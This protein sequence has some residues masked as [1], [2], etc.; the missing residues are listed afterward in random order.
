VLAARSGH[1]ANVALARKMRELYTKK[2]I[3]GRYNG[4]KR[5]ALFDINAILK[6]MPHRY[7]M[8]L[9][10][11]IVDLVPD[12]SVVAIKNVTI[13]EPF[14]QGHFPGQPIMP[15]VLILEAMGQAGG[16]LLL[17][18]IPEPQNKLVYFVSIDN[19]KFRRPVTPG[20]QLRFELDMLAF[21]RGTCKMS[22]KA[23]VED[24]LVASADFMAM[25]M[26][27]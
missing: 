21:R 9:I 4:K 13:N 12:R 16:V 2:K 5:E 1:K 15:G 22:G 10:D 18:A 24:H 26:D 19:A 25:V 27:R 8:L 6:I 17:N 23:F 7:P 14:F 20:D 3:A 11:R